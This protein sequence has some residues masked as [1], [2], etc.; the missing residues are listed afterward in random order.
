[1]KYLLIISALFV[2]FSGVFAGS[3]VELYTGLQTWAQIQQG[4]KLLVTLQ[5]GTYTFDCTGSDNYMTFGPASST[6][7]TPQQVCCSPDGWAGSSIGILTIITP[8]DIYC[9]SA[10]SGCDTNYVLHITGTTATDP[11]EIVHPADNGI[12]DHTIGTTSTLDIQASGGMAPYTWSYS[13]KGIL[14][15]PGGQIYGITSDVAGEFMCTLTVTDSLNQEHT[16]NFMIRFNDGN[17]TNGLD[18]T[19]PVD[20]SGLSVVPGGSLTVTAAATGGTPPYG[21]HSVCNVTA[22][23]SS[24]LTF[25]AFGKDVGYTWTCSF[26]VID[27]YNVSHTHSFTVVVGTDPTDP[28]DPGDDPNSTNTFG[29]L[30]LQF[31]DLLKQIKGKLV[32][33]F[34]ALLN[35]PSGPDFSFTYTPDFSNISPHLSVPMVFDFGTSDNPAV[36][37]MR[38]QRNTIRNIFK[39][40]VSLCFVFLFG[41][42][43][44]YGG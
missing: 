2:S 24:S 9:C 10:W 8:T 33:N 42:I 16:H 30:A 31:L 4:N 26:T 32:I 25:D 29:D 20:G 15:G 17:S 37:A 11:L 41:R 23:N 27:S 35:P 22:S 34:D 39:F 40:F 1:M 13:G 18:I 19:N 38:T 44:N 43:L 6:V 7:E 21:W 5:P 12:F 28:N 36:V 3:F 14:D